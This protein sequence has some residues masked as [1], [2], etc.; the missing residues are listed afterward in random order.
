MRSTATETE[1]ELETI[2]WGSLS[3]VRVTMWPGETA[4]K[5]TNYVY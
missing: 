3:V 1:L 5:P 4:E 2:L